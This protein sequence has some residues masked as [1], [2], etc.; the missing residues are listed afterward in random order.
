MAENNDRAAIISSEGG[1][2]DI[3]S[4]IYTKNVNI[5]V[6]LKG[7][8]G[9]ALRVDR[10]GRNSITVMNPTLTLMLMVQPSVLSGLMPN[11]TFCGRGLTARFLYCISYCI[12]AF[13]IYWDFFGLQYMEYLYYCKNLLFLFSFHSAYDFLNTL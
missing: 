12:P 11:N 10:I 13:H 6:I 8:S 2:F 5:D 9:D 1:I 7:Y 3:L 4:G